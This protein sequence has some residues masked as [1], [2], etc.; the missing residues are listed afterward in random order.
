MR[1]GREAEGRFSHKRTQRTQRGGRGRILTELTEGRNWE[2]RK[3]FAQRTAEGKAEEGRSWR[4]M[5]FRGKQERSPTPA[6]GSK[7][8]NE[9]SCTVARRSTATNGR[10]FD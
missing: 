7:L 3:G 10:L 2:G 5:E 8:G 4:E 1:K 6:E 9:G